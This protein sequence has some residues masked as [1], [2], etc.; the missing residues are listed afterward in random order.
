MPALDLWVEVRDGKVVTEPSLLPDRIKFISSD[1]AV[2]RS[3]GWYPVES[4]K[5]DTFSDF[6][7]VW[8]QS[9]FDVQEEKVV[10]TLVKRSKTAEELQKQDEIK[11]AGERVFRDRLLS[12]CDWVIVKSIEADV[13]NIDDW[14]TYRQALRDVPDQEGFPWTIDWPTA[15]EA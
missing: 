8:D 15:P 9:T 11:S 5:P 14:K 4:I 6:L 2:L 7:E 1:R 10:W 12:M 13:P 3:H